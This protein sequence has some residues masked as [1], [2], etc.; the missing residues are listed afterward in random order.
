[1]QRKERKNRKVTDN[2]H[3]T[4]LPGEVKPKLKTRKGR[5]VGK[6][7]YEAA[8]YSDK[9]WGCGLEGGG[10]RVVVGGGFRQKSHALN[11]PDRQKRRLIE[12]TG[13]LTGFSQTD[14]QTGRRKAVRQ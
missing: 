5:L 4:Q 6:R 14:R 8:F 2:D 13:R 12:K 10:W 3:Q 9:W 11:Q 1:M 7:L